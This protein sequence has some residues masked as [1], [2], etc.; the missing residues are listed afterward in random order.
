MK[1]LVF[2]VFILLTGCCQCILPQIPLQ[3]IFTGDNCQSLLPDYTARVTVSDNCRIASII[4]IP[5]AGFILSDTSMIIRVIIR[6]TD[7]SG[8]IAQTFFDVA[9][10]DTI[11]PIIIV[12]STLLTSDMDIIRCLYDQADRIILRALENFD[13]KFPYS[14][15]GIPLPDSAQFYNNYLIMT[16]TPLKQEGEIGR[17]FSLVSYNFADTLTK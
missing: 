10:I 4:Q 2:F 13:A 12:D 11:P 14:E 3:Y 1:K 16:R 15:L 7:N 6:A 17:V 9:L 5:A 8:N